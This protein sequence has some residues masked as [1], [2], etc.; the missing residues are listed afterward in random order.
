MIFNH[1]PDKGDDSMAT[2][3]LRFDDIMK[4]VLDKKVGEMG[5]NLTTFCVDYA[6]RTLRNRKIPFYISAPLSL[7]TPNPIWCGKT[8]YGPRSLLWPFSSVLFPASA[9][10]TFGFSLGRMES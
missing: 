10:P 8:I 2:V 4:K 3:T 5:I 6:K 7:S 9:H 1:N